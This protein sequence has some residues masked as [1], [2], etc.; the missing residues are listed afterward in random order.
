MA[1]QGVAAF[2]LPGGRSLQTQRRHRQ[3][4]ACSG[5]WIQRCHVVAASVT[6][7]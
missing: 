6:R 2:T 1:G 4:V 3:D 5:V 7:R